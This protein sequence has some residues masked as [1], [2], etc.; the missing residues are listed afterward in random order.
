MTDTIPQYEY[1]GGPAEAGLRKQI[2]NY[3]N[4]VDRAYFDGEAGKAN[5][6][7]FCE[8]GF[9]SRSQMDLEE[10]SEV[11]DWVRDEWP[12]E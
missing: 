6:A 4:E 1:V 5:K 3:C 7:V 12:I 11:L 8:F 2:N 9:K 10:L